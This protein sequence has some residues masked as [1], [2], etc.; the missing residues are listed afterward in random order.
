LDGLVD[1][2]YQLVLGKELALDLGVAVGDQVTLVAPNV[3]ATPVGMMP[4]LKRF[5]VAG[6]F[7]VGM[8]EYD[9]GIALVSM[10]DAARVMRLGDQVTGV[11]L[12]MQDLYRAPTVSRQVAVSLPS[13][14]RVVDWTMR[15][16][17][18]FQALQMEKR[19]MSIILFLIVAVAAFNIVSTLVMMVTDKQSDIAILRTLGFG[20]GEVMWVFITQGTL[21]GLVGTLLGLAAGIPLAFNLEAFVAWIEGLFGI[22]FLDPNIYYISRL[23]S[24]VQWADVSAVASGAFLLSLLATLYPA[25]RAGRT[26][27]VEALRYE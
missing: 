27:P 6:I 23:P 8:G 22:R 24:D 19:M 4:R 16:R 21:I 9:R 17:N 12:K 5:S 13:V 10:T 2:S 20:S 14:Y 11:R 15:H 26:Q 1:R 3:A 25:W 7:E 18:F